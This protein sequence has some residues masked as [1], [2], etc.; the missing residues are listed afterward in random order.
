MPCR[1][2]GTACEILSPKGSHTDCLTTLSSDLSGKSLVVNYL[3]EA[4]ILS[5][6]SATRNPEGINGEALSEG[7]TARNKWVAKDNKSGWRMPHDEYEM[8]FSR[9]IYCG[10]DTVDGVPMCRLCMKELE[11]GYTNRRRTAIRKPRI[12][13][14]LLIAPWAKLWV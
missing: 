12:A 3:L 4:P 13:H 5:R 6:S 11:R 1:R 7:R 2:L 8:L 14:K 9:C 10:S